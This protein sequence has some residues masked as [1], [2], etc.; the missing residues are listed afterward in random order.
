MSDIEKEILKTLKDIQK[1]IPFLA[2]SSVKDVLEK[3][4]KSPEKL[5]VYSLSDGKNKIRDI[6]DK[7]GVSFGAIQ[8]W[9][10]S[11]Y[12]VGIAEEIPSGRGT[13]AVALFDLAEF[14][15]EIPTLIITVEKPPSEEDE[16][17]E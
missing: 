3:T 9:W 7:T 12:K 15:I 2:W 8:S 5:V 10:K 11:W 4:L 16:E 13:R 17:T 6:R 14:E 1:W